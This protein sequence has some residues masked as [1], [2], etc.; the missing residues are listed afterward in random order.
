MAD[1]ISQAKIDACV[2]RIC[3]RG[4]RAVHQ[5]L[6]NLRQGH[7]VEALEG[8]SRSERAAVT[9][10]LESVMAVYGSTSGAGC[11]T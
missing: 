4:C 1:P 5:V 10:E 6:E 2:E 3:S 8:L 9:A 7:G 11:G